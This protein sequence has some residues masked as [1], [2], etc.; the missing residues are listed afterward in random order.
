MQIANAHDGSSRLF[1]V[2][3]AGTI[4]HLQGRRAAPDAVPRHPHARDLLRRAGAAV[5]GV[6][7][8]LRVE[9][10]LLRLLH[11]QAREPRRH[12]HRA[13]QRVGR[14]R[15]RRSRVGAD[16]ARR[17]APDQLQPQRR[18]AL[19]QPG[20]RIPLRGHGRRRRRRRPARTTPRTPTSCS[21]R[22]SAST[23]TA[24]A[25][26]PAGSRRRCPTR[27][28]ASNP[29]AGSPSDCH[30]IWAYG[31]R[32]PWRYSFDR[33]TGDLLIGDVGQE[34][35]E[36]VDFQPAASAGGENYG[37]HK[38]E[39]FH[40][41]NPS[42][43]CDDGTLTMP[44]LEQPAQLGLVRDHRRHALPRDRDPGARR[45]VPL[46]GQLPGRHLF[47]DTGRRRELDHGAA[48]VDRLQRLR[49]RGRRG[50]RGLLRGSRRGQGLPGRSLALPGAGRHQRRAVLG[51]RRRSGLHPDG[52]RIGLR[53][54]VGR[55]LERRGPA[56]HA[57]SRPP[58]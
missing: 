18:A 42:T 27:S 41:Y 36:E 28:R 23:S 31:M 53:L 40:C 38:M 56:D 20:G 48:Q 7:P 16:P 24:R 34:L 25:P 11:Q 4:R 51:H 10:L 2:E 50:R 57:S 55:A 6:P 49:L 39:G 5:G 37:W 15:R 12:H 52:Q 3:Q 9:R 8:G 17:A 45:P 13:V 46:L 21:A 32:N 54:R 44:I 1:V 58:S 14:P 33:V 22:C 30:E 29:F 26:F 43:N 47:G 19:L 35:Y